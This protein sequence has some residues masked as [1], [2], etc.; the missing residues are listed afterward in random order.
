MLSESHLPP[1]DVLLVSDDT[2]LD[3]SAQQQTEAI[4][5]TALLQDI[6]GLSTLTLVFRHC[7]VPLSEHQL[8]VVWSESENTLVVFRRSFVLVQYG[9]V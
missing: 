3:V 4:V 8:Q 7:N 1:L 5:V 9:L 6:E 2:C